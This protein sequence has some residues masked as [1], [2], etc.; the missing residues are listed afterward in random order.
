MPL[1][2]AELR[3]ACE[4]KT[5]MRC[6]GYPRAMF[7]HQ[8]FEAEREVSLGFKKGKGGYFE[9]AD[10]ED[11]LGEWGADEPAGAEEDASAPS[12]AE[13]EELV[14]ADRTQA[15]L[16]GA[17]FWHDCRNQH[18]SADAAMMELLD[19]V[20][21]EHPTRCAIEVRA[22]AGTATCVA[23][24]ND[25]RDRAASVLDALSLMRSEK[26]G[27][28][29]LIGENGVGLKAAAAKLG[30]GAVVL[31]ARRAAQSFVI[32]RGA[33]RET[34][35]E[36][37]AVF[38]VG[39][40][41][42]SLQR[43]GRPP[44]IPI[45]VFA[46]RSL[47]GVGR[48]WA[49]AVRDSPPAAKTAEACGGIVDVE[50]ACRSLAASILDED[51][52]A[53]R[54][55]THASAFEVVLFDTFEAAPTV[56]RK[57]G[58]ILRGETYLDRAFVAT[59]ADGVGEPGEEI[60]PYDLVRSLMEPARERVEV[61]RDRY[62]TVV[63]GF[64][65]VSKHADAA[66][67]LLVYTK[68]RLVERHDDWRLALNLRQHLKRD[69][70]KEYALGLTVV[71]IDEAGCLR[72]THTKQRIVDDVAFEVAKGGAAT[73]AAD[74]FVAVHKRTWMGLGRGGAQAGE[75]KWRLEVNESLTKVL[76]LASRG[77][78]RRPARA[79]VPLRT[80]NLLKLGPTRRA[81]VAGA[82][83][84]EDDEGRADA[85]R[86][87]AFVRP[88]PPPKP[89]APKPA[90]KRP[91]AAPDPA[92][93][94]TVGTQ[95]E[96]KFR[97]GRFYPAVV[98]GHAAAGDTF[99]V[100]FDDGDAATVGRAALKQLRRARKAPTRLYDEDSEDEESPRKKRK[101]RAAPARRVVEEDPVAR[102]RDEL[103]A[104]ET[105]ASKDIYTGSWR[106]V[107]G[108]WRR[109]IEDARTPRAVLQLAEELER[110]G[111]GDHGKFQVWLG[112]ER[113]VAARDE[114]L[115][116]GMTRSEWLAKCRDDTRSVDEA[117]ERLQE[118]DFFASDGTIVVPQRGDADA[119]T[120]AHATPGDAAALLALLPSRQ[121]ATNPLHRERF[122]A[123]GAPVFVADAT[124]AAAR[125]QAFS[126]CADADSVFVVRENYSD[127]QARAIE[128]GVRAV[129]ALDPARTD[130][131]AVTVRRCP[132][133]LVDIVPV[134]ADDPRELLRGQSRCVAR[135]AIA[136]HEVIGAYGGRLC[137]QDAY[138]K[139]RG[140]SVL[141]LVE[142]ER[143]ALSI[144][145]PVRGREG[146]FGRLVIDPWP[147]LGEEP[148][149]SPL[150]AIND[151]RANPFLNLTRK[152]ELENCA[153]VNAYVRGFAHVF[154]V[155]TRDI[156]AGQE[157][158]IDY[159]ESYWKERAVMERYMGP[160]RAA[161]QPEELD[162]LRAAL[163]Q[164]R[165]E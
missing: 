39:V 29:A 15:Q 54:R 116:P 69:F 144:D 57:L 128:T 79:L 30:G 45:A 36:G 14:V 7:V 67:P 83:H 92:E 115:C 158:L 72:Q 24:R 142:A 22:R 47:D 119:G 97:D 9:Q 90:P 70:R 56:A 91:R 78:A 42:E 46:A 135:R 62:V 53:P 26:R 19:N 141:D 129:V 112:Q 107:Q 77:A 164:R 60:E 50:A 66:S 156:V 151:C 165:G 68:G 138:E 12:A 40:L 74:Y 148:H 153:F 3:A 147:G 152:Y 38:E 35:G 101:K 16:D 136:K 21:D 159:K 65:T 150:M 105:A 99:D 71:I 124:A 100:R 106:G 81:G 31:T 109:R 20:A 126:N 23:L 8:V 111:W 5:K 117:L 143:F 87:D 95:V 32:R 155:A 85:F 125:A 82:L 49:A 51:T 145:K 93:P 98:T 113:A 10:F 140:R 162:R 88:P 17:G 58:E 61:G 13:D 133:A 132:S 4:T 18:S 25:V 137:A 27:P 80:A 161:H 94:Y 96:A 108:A 154:V 75:K 86:L 84:P 104:M 63:V 1:S 103:L 34:V 120:L 28:G 59:I 110:D 76:D 139:T 149:G 44:V 64:S 43:A 123:A 52:L 33:R 160:F 146:G 134:P 121:V 73:F 41:A 11:V 163:V 114:G 89:P 131:G 122:A 130:D 6:D 102:L 55:A 157:L 127:A 118:L 37:A 2:L 48:A